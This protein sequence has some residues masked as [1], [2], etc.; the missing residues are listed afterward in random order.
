MGRSLLRAFTS[1]AVSFRFLRDLDRSSRDITYPI[2]VPKVSSPNSSTKIQVLEEKEYP[3]DYRGA[4]ASEAQSEP[5]S[6]TDINDDRQEAGSPM[7]SVDQLIQAG[8]SK[9]PDLVF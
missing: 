3:T 7:E 4:H 1:L 9:G 8:E 2:S 5:S 6:E